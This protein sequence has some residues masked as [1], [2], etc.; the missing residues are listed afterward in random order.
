MS[1]IAIRVENLSKMYR[2]GALQR[3]ARYAT[4]RE[5]LVEMVSAPFKSLSR[6][7]Q[8]EEL[9]ALKDVSF[10]VKHGEVVGIIGRNG[11][12]KSTLLKLLARITKPTSGRA[13][14]Y[15]RVGSLLEVGTGFHP[16]LTGRENIYMNGAILGMTKDEIRRKFDEIV[17]FS[18]IEE[19]LDTPVKR[20][21]SG[22]SVR[23]AFSVAAHLEPEILIVDEVLA[24]GDAAFQKKCMGKMGDVS[25]QGRTVLFVSHNMPAVTRLCQTGI[26]L[27]H[28]RSVFQGNVDDA[29][30]YY[31]D[32]M[33][34]M[35]AATQ[36]DGR[37]VFPPA[38]DLPA[39]ILELAVKNPQGKITSLVEYQDPFD[40]FFKLH[41]RDPKRGYYAFLTLFDSIGNRL[42]FTSDT[43]LEPSLIAEKQAGVYQY[44]A[45]FP[46]KFLKPGTYFLSASISRQGAGRVDKKE[47]ALKIEVEDSR[48]WRAQN[49]GYR[50]NTVIA[51]EIPW[52]LEQLS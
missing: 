11:A 34:G 44:K 28:G 9:W 10:E 19:F 45:T 48:S 6:P 38:P 2:I 32:S 36:I 23:L 40:V 37:N 33:E 20:Y 31:V 35:Q 43:D 12:G 15:G 27:N 24:V 42:I 7:A 21:S 18:E 26:V 41:V 25:Q 52:E 46:A 4:L 39:Q 16:E 13:E 1:D 8:T 30:S 29:I 3:T 5:S 47:F 49:N 14:I 22:M 51:P 17:A 50:N